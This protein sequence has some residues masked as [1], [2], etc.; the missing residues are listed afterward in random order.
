MNRPTLGVRRDASR[1]LFRQPTA[2]YL[3][4]ARNQHI[5]EVVKGWPGGLTTKA[6]TTP[7]VAS[8]LGITSIADISPIIAPAS[9]FSALV[10]SGITVSLAGV[11]SK[12]VP[13]RIVSG[14]D[15]GNFVVEGGPIPV[16]QSTISAGPEIK[17]F[18][19]ACIVVL[20]RELAEHSVSD[21]EVIIQS[22]LS[23]AATLKLDSICLGSAAATAAQPQGLLFGVSAAGTATPNTAGA[24]TALAG[25]IEKLMSALAANGAGVSPIF[26]CA[27]PQVASMRLLCG[28]RFDYPV[29]A[30]VGVTAGTIIAVEGPSFVSGFSG[31]PEFFTSTQAVLHMDSAPTALSMVGSPN[32]VSAPDRS[33]YQSDC[34]AVKMV[35][36]VGWGL[37]AS[38]HA[39]YISSVAW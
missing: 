30:S 22:M 5:A 8:D 24:I 4:A 25:D 35:L 10:A 20:T 33:I 7:M 15:A 13:A 19:L 9:A 12:F 31:V 6:V 37:R 32:L 28:L 16:T 27:P 3:A 14:A 23:E 36:R 18:K 21:A 38:G 39:T 17:P 11:T 2:Q 1:M 34:V 26:I 29:I